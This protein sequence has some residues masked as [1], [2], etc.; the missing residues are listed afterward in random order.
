MKPPKPKNDKAGR[1]PGEVGKAKQ[2]S[3]KYS[4]RST[5]TAAQLD[6]LVSMLRVRQRHTHEL[7]MQGISHPAGRI[8]DL[9]AIGFVI[10]SDRINTVDGDGF[11]HTNVALYSIVSEPETAQ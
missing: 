3:S 9:E 7:R 2:S 10:A 11:I 4:A 6:R 8:Q 5:A 1:Q